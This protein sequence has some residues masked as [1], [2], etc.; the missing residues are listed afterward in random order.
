MDVEQALSS[1]VDNLQFVMGFDQGALIWNA[2]A[3]AHSTLTEL[4][5][6]F[7]Y[8]L[9]ARSE[10]MLVYPGFTGTCVD[11][12][13]TAKRNGYSQN[14]VTVSRKFMAICGSNLTMDDNAIPDGSVIEVFTRSG[15]LCGAGRYEQGLLKMTPVYGYD[16]ADAS[17]A[18]LPQIGDSLT[19][20]IDGIHSYPDVVW[21]GQGAVEKLGRRTSSP[22]SEEVLPY[23][24][25]LHQNYPNPFNAGTVISFEVTGSTDLEIVICNVLGQ[26]IRQLA[27]GHYEPGEYRVHWDGR[28]EQGI[29]VSS[30]V[31]FYRL[32]AEGHSQTRKMLFV[33]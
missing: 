4:K 23:G 6:G 30:G 17:T 24:F 13:V 28:D 21:E 19:V 27:C 8:W 25:E 26:T 33:K 2:N 22:Q 9:R 7:G 31:Y 1:I 29:I 32:L 12:T 3:P 15:Q 5:P 16:E 10:G 18:R 11:E 14:P 20:H